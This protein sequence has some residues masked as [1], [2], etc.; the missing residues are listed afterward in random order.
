MIFAL[1]AVALAQESMQFDPVFVSHF[2][3]AGEVS[4]ADAELL[5]AAVERVIARDHI[6]I[7]REDVPRYEDYDAEVYLAS[8]TPAQRTGCAYVVGER[9]GSSWVI[10]GLVYAPPDGS[11]EVEVAFLDVKNT[12][13]PLVVRIP[14]NDPVFAAERVSELMSSVMA[15]PE[16]EADVRE[17][18]PAL[19]RARR[20]EFAAAAASDLDKLEKELGGPSERD[21]IEAETRRLTAA[22]LEGDVERDDGAPWERLGMERGEYL[23]YRNSGK[24]LLAWKAQMR[25]RAARPVLALS[26]GIGSG[27]WGELLDARWVLDDHLEHLGTEAFLEVQNSNSAD[28][29]VEVGYGLHP[30]LQV[31][32]LFASRNSAVEWVIHNE[33]AGQVETA[34]VPEQSV[35]PT[36]QIGGRADVIPFPWREVRPTAGGGVSLWHGSRFNLDTESATFLPSF[37]TPTLLIVQGGPGVEAQLSSSLLLFGRG[38]VLLAVGDGTQAVAEPGA[39]ALLHRASPP[40]W[41]PLGWQASFGVQILLAPLFAPKQPNIEEEP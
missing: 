6:A 8:C 15:N 40:G 22:D 12:R 24:P 31:S 16:A 34:P 36:W 35:V 21:R 3:T 2:A 1:A 38:E 14:A 37:H 18:D 27:P 32:A 33:I 5:R 28:V 7:S 4:A 13:I 9:S 10:S 25:G 20:K 39:E 41:S 30:S 29:Q 23:R 17:E 19:T 26:G 11:L